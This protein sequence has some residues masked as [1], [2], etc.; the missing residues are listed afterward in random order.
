[1]FTVEV[2]NDTSMCWPVDTTVDFLNSPIS[3]C[4]ASDLAGLF[5]DR[6]VDTDPKSVILE[7]SW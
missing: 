5:G 1:M 6:D 2:T 4:A 3:F 7:V